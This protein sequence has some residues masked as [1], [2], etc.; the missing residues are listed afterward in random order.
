MT[1]IF[2]SNRY[3]ILWEKS[4]VETL[5]MPVQMTEQDCARM[6][7]KIVTDQLVP[8]YQIYR[9]LIEG[10]LEEYGLPQH[11]INSILHEKLIQMMVNSPYPTAQ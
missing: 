2:I 4:V 7:E 6:I 11:L 8:I 10:G 3:V 1:I 9:A 5:R